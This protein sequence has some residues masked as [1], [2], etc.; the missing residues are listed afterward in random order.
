MS[1]RIWISLETLSTSVTSM[2]LSFS[3]IF[4]AT[5]SPVSVC[6]PFFTLPN[7]PSPIVFPGF[8]DCEE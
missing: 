5:V 8:E 4:I 3:K 6:F 1:L 2:I 7:V